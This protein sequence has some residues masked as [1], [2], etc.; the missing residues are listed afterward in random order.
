MIGNCW[1]PLRVKY[2]DHVLLMGLLGFQAFNWNNFLL[3]ELGKNWYLRMWAKSH[4]LLL[5]LLLKLG[6]VYMLQH[7]ISFFAVATNLPMTPVISNLDLCHPPFHASGSALCPEDQI[8]AIV[9]FAVV[10]PQPEFRINVF[11][12]GA[13][14]DLSQGPPIC[15]H[16]FIA[17]LIS[18][19]HP[20]E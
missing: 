5:W 3:A 19:S 8:T 17:S 14:P 9:G 2:T 20:R 18:Y 4:C 13:L 15:L 12:P 1:L 16:C 6:R 7:S 10:S 11:P